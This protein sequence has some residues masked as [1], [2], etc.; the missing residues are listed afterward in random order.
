MGTTSLIFA[1]I[2]AAFSLILNTTLG[3]I[4]SS[5]KN[6]ERIFRQ[7]NLDLDYDALCSRI[8]TCVYVSAFIGI[9]IL[10]LILT[11]CYNI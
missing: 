4:H 5:L 2:L 11:L 7:Y 1:G 9:F 10:I 8:K 3:N 6:M